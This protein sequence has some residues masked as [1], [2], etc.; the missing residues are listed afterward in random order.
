[1]FDALSDWELGEYQRQMIL[2]FVLSSPFDDPN[3]YFETHQALVLLA[4]D[5]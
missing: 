4:L 3:A 1:M 2:D 5:A